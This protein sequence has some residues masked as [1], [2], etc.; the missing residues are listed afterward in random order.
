VISI[1]TKSKNQRYTED[2]LKRLN[3][4]DPLRKLPEIAQMGVDKLKAATPVKTGKTRDAWGYKIEKTGNQSIIYWTNDNFADGIP[5]IILLEYGHATK[6][7]G[8][9]MGLNLIHPAMKT[10]YQL[11]AD[12]VWK[13]VIGK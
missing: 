12:G 13:E 6:T 7:G 2:F 3:R 4:S 10:V 9:V 5:V 11:A 1:Q 8:F